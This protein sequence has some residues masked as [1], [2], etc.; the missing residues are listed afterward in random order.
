ME[1]QVT[2]KNV[3]GKELIYPDCTKSDILCKRVMKKQTFNDSDIANLKLLGY[4]FTV[5]T[6]QL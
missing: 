5:N 3:Y 4:S 6:K 1:L 2:I